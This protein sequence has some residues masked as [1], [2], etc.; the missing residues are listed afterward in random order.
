MDQATEPSILI[1]KRRCKLEHKLYRIPILFLASGETFEAANRW[2]RHLALSGRKFLT[3]KQYAYCLLAFLKF[4]ATTPGPNL[5]R[6]AWDEISNS[7]IRMWR[8][9]M[10]LDERKD[11]TLRDNV[12][13]LFRF[14]E[15]AYKNDEFD[16]PVLQS[17]T[18]GDFG[19]IARSEI[20]TSV[21]EIVYA[22]PPTTEDMEGVQRM[23]AAHGG[24]HLKRDMLMFRWAKQA[25]LRNSDFRKMR[26]SKFFSRAEIKSLESKDQPAIL[27]IKSKRGKTRSVYPPLSLVKDTREYLDSLPSHLVAAYDLIFFGPNGELTQV[28]VSKLFAYYFKLTGLDSHIHRARAYYLYQ[29]ILGK[30]RELAREGNLNDFSVQTVLQ[31]TLDVAGHSDADTLKYYVNLARVSLELKQVSHI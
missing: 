7:T 30:L 13:A 15:W 19:A 9:S 16:T 20:N 24:N 14:L 3:L 2:L 6:L 1:P 29:L 4:L 26:A 31:F 17:L 8:N 18:R 22:P 12:N 25:G 11:T 28:Y 10:E 27:R 21:H 5:T 23:I